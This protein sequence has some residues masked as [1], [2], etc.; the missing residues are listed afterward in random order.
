MREDAARQAGQIGA[1]AARERDQLRS[2][3]EARAAALEWARGDLR[4]QADRAD[5]EAR[6]ARGE[7]D[8]VTAPADAALAKLEEVLGRQDNPDLRVA[9]NE[10]RTATGAGPA[11]PRRRGHGRHPEPARTSS[12]R[13]R[14]PSPFAV[15]G[16]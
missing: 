8:Q 3:L 10:F 16:S 9:V 15:A 11:E 14:S 6:W 1:D 2:V 12:P 5:Q 7:R 4:S 13:P